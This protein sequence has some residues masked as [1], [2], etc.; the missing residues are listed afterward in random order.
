LGGEGVVG[1][2]RRFDVVVVGGGPAGLSAAL[3]LGRARRRVLLCDAGQG[4]NAPAAGVH[5]F[6]TRDGTPPAEL[7]RI[8]RE[9]LI[10][11][12]AAFHDGAV[13]GARK[14]DGGFEVDLADG[15]RVACRKLIL[16]TGMVDEL[17][18]IPG[19]RERWGESV[20]HCPYCHG[21]EHRGRPWA[22][23][24]E[25]P[26]HVAEMATLALGWTDRIAV[27]TH[28][29][30]AIAAD[31]RAWLAGR[32]IAVAEGRIEGLEGEGRGLSAVRLEGGG[33]VEA[34]AMLARPR[35][36]QG[37]PLPASLGCTFVAE[38]PTAGM[39]EVDATGATGVEGLYVAGDASAGAPSVARAVAEG[40]MA[41]A[42]GANRAMLIEDAG[43]PAPARPA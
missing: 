20:I 27:L 25:R 41:A 14:V 37:S 4:R 19:L 2:I 15:G 39:V 40:A 21:W 12:G 1:E 36:R 43:A 9:Q 18:D 22:L 24:A 34:A 6:L 16:A 26:E 33:R 7:R 29:P 8:A 28:G 23:L 10:P 35:P 5:G 11:Y 3:V 30:A 32:G 13:A 42:A 31:V 38:A 17:P